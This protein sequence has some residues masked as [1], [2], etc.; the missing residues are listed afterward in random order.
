MVDQ[1]DRGA[2]ARVAHW[3]LAGVETMAPNV[4][5]DCTTVASAFRHYVLSRIA[6]FVRGE[7][8]RSRMLTSATGKLT[9]A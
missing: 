2:T 3:V 5:N 6:Q 7:R 1:H 9:D 8:G 4:P